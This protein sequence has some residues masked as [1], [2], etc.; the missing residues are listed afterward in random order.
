MITVKEFPIIDTIKTEGI[1]AEKIET[2]VFENL[3]LKNRSPFNENY[4]KNDLETI[5]SNLQNLGYYFATVDIILNNL[6][7]NKVNLIFK[8]DLGEKAKIKKIKFL[9]NKIFKDRKLKM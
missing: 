5:K 1:K 3:L 4:L 6:E 9:G 8:V 7:D 2:K